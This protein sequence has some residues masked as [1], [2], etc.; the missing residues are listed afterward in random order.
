MGLLLSSA[1]SSSSLSPFTSALESS[2]YS[3]RSYLESRS[4]SHMSSSS[5]KMTINSKLPILQTLIAK[6]DDVKEKLNDNEYKQIVETVAMISKDQY[7]LID[8][9]KEILITKTNKTKFVFIHPFIIKSFLK[10]LYI[11][12]HC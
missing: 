12:V 1:Y 8:V 3:S 4:L 2:A 10:T 9:N 7:K 11:Y 5:P 6:I